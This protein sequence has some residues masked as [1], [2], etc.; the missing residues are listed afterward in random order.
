MHST[1]THSTIERV[2]RR[3]HRDAQAA[4][5]LSSAAPCLHTAVPF[6]TIR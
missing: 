2:S 1:S 6:D 4:R 5:L 3:G